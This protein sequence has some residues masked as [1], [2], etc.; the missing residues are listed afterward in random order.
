MKKIASNPNPVPS[1][2]RCLMGAVVWLAVATPGSASAADDA[3]DA[4]PGTVNPLTFYGT[5]DVMSYR[6]QDNS[7]VQ[8]S[9]NL[10]GIRETI[11]GVRTSDPPEGSN[12]WRGIGQ[13]E[14]A[15]GADRGEHARMYT[16]VARQTFVGV[17]GPWGQLT[18][19]RQYN[20]LTNIA[21]TALNPINNGWGIY[22]NDLL[23]LGD[24]F[25]HRNNN[26][27]DLA[28]AGSNWFLGYTQDGAQYQFKGAGYSVQ[29][30]FV[31]GGSPGGLFGRGATTTLGGTKDLGQ[32]TLAGAA[33][34]QV[35]RDGAADRK[36]GVLGGVYGRDSLK[37]YLSRLESR[38][39]SGARYSVDYG[40]VGWQAN[41]KLHVSAALARYRQNGAALFGSGSARGISAVAEYAL[42][43]HLNVYVETDY[44]RHVGGSDGAQAV[45][46]TP[47][48]ARN[49][50]LGLSI[51]F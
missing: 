50:M 2:A 30:E 33:S 40:G 44:R 10:N 28:N 39:S 14:A 32:W 29:A 37:L 43:P 46:A 4:V 25:T 21:W 7:G 51:S 36:V 27:R 13:V 48:S 16:V 5:L 17:A 45:F 47:G 1:R 15:F 49:F 3:V 38:V 11:L 6:F 8:R 24:S 31:P 12:D 22:F 41:P 35:S 26:A 9:W 20:V 19:G 42:T 23:Y 34:R 18:L